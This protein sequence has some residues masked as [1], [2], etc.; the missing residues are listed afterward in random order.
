MKKELEQI[1][2]LTINELLNKEIILPSL[3]FEK[4]NYH[5]KKVEINLDDEEFQ[6]E[7]EQILVDDYKNIEKYMSLII[8]SVN[9]L[10]QETQNASNAILNNDSGAL[11]DIHKRM[12]TLENEIQLLNDELFIDDL[13]KSYNKKWIYNKFLDE[14][15]DFKDEGV[16]T[17]V[18]IEDFN[19]IQKEYGELLAKNLLIFI[20]NFISQKLK[21]EHYNFHIARYFHNK[22]FIFVLEKD[23]NQIKNFLLN[24]EQMLLNTT[25][26]SHSGL[27]IKASYKFKTEP[28]K[29]KDK[30]KV[31]F[32][33]LLN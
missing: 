11:T 6:K 26:K 32:D 18:D 23:K 12:I 27:Y 31:V 33:K 5:A 13:T 19:Y 20:I 2:N 1:T 25:L 14:N 9:E 29:V 17:L 7:V 22:F 16:C 3:Y 8:S 15:T 28:F 24:L 21:D 30:S 4:F 10:K